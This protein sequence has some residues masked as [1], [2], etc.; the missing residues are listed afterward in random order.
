MKGKIFRSV[1]AVAI[2]VFAAS[3]IIIMGVL[4]QYFTA[5][6][7]NDLSEQLEL[8]SA[9]V[10]YAGEDYFS[11]LDFGEYRITW[12]DSEG[13]VLFDSA[14]RAGEL[15]NHGDRPEIIDALK[16]GYGESTRYSTTLSERTVYAA[17][18]LKDGTVLRISSEY[19]TMLTISISM[20]RPILV[21]LLIAMIIAALLANRLS[22]H[23]VKPLLEIDPDN[24]SEGD[25]YEEITPIL[26]RL[27]SQHRKINEQLEELNRRRTEFETITGSMNE[28][29]VLLSGSGVIL[30]INPAAQKIFGADDSAAG[31]NFLEVDRS[32]DISET[33]EKAGECGHGES[34]IDRGGRKY[35]LDITK[36]SGEEGSGLVMLI[37]DVTER[38]TGEQER[39]EFTANVSHE[40]KTPLQSIMGSAELLENGLVKQADVPKFLGRIRSESARLVTLIDDI[41]RLSRLEEQQEQVLET[42]DLKSCAADNINILTDAA[43][44]KNV[45]I[46]L[47]G[48]DAVIYSSARLCGEIIYN[49]IDN[50]VKYN[51]VGGSVDIS[52]KDCGDHAV[53]VVSDTGIGIP[54]EDLGRIFERFYRAD[55]SRS[56]ER[57]GTG[58]GLSIV[59]HAVMRLGGEV[60]VKS[61]QDVGTSITVKFPKN[62]L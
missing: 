48:D 35:Q 51:K 14:D 30:S 27:E 24:P 61:R 13:N 44:K 10:E 33:A 16:N 38:I 41:I 37:F 15:E 4:Y 50:A 52:I 8:A 23:I 21:V 20:L 28:G 54:E 55:K 60:S 42:V 49:L 6:Q 22:K 56:K 45:A 7:K 1:M 11:E 25:C 31:R 40:L 57:G 46:T 39:R 43:E 12:V 18:R 53:L 47:S 29:L 58:L 59:K 9:G 36:I 17:K 2:A 26:K 19:Y 32:R 34:I 62:N 3:V 5:V